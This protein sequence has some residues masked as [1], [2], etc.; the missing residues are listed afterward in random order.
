MSDFKCFVNKTYKKVSYPI[1]VVLEPMYLDHLQPLSLV[2]D[3]I[4]SGEIL[5]IEF[6][7]NKVMRLFLVEDNSLNQ[8]FGEPTAS[9]AILTLKC[10]D[11]KKK[12]EIEQYIKNIYSQLKLSEMITNKNDLMDLENELMKYFLICKNKDKMEIRKI[13]SVIF[14]SC[15]N[16][17]FAE[18][19]YNLI[20]GQAFSY[21]TS[22]QTTI[23]V[24]LSL[25]SV[26]IKNG[27]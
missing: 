8:I 23:Q 11:L 20:K 17:K 14:K 2:I 15:K 24:D 22:T 27:A 1:P 5:I 26:Q 3:E 21:F 10:Q 19:I 9:N 4:K 13:R 7:E 12:L 18:K 25:L 6:F 16:H